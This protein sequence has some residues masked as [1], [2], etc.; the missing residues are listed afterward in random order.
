MKKWAYITGVLFLILLLGTGY[1]KVSDRDIPDSLFYLFVMSAGLF[2]FT[3]IFA[4]LKR[5][6]NQ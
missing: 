2:F 3:L 4:A 5:G 1:F 6:R